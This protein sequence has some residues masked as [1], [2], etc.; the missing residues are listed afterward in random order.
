MDLFGED[1]VEKE[2]DVPNDSPAFFHED[3]AEG[4]TVPRSSAFMIGHGAQEQG[5]LKQFK[6]GRIPHGIILSGPKGIGKSTFAFRLGRFLLKHGGE[7]DLEGF[8]DFNVPAS[9]NVF[10]Q[11]A[12]GGHSDLL[13]VERA[14]DAAKDTYKNNV[15]VD[16]IRKI[17]PFL[18][19]TAS[20]KNGWRVVVI[21]DADTM[22]R[23]AQN[24]LLKILEEP[25]S[26]TVIILVCHRL[27]AM[28]ATIRSRAHVVSMDTLVQD[29]FNLLLERADHVLDDLES[30]TLY[31]LSG[32]SFGAA[33]DYI[34][35]GGF[36]TLSLI[37]NQLKNYP[38]WSWVEL[39]KLADQLV[40]AGRDQ[41]YNSFVQLLP[42]IFR[43]MIEAK[44]RGVAI[45][46]QAL[47]NET[48][49]NIHAHSS[50]EHLMNICENLKEHFARVERSNLDKRQ[51]V[52]GAFSII[53]A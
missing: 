30:D 40:R 35:L 23:N 7:Q 3:A 34:Q 46:S 17:N 21:D 37:L 32:G 47:Q 43:S 11:V 5:L 2:Q 45:N 31:N 33:L 52:L 22:N 15:V 27:G 18:H 1:I 4:L 48:V 25:P 13:V 36:D 51:A 10:K 8:E 29:D 26:N 6:T 12:S 50:L 39:H 44:A 16:D 28:V 49:Q 20:R 9:D 53:A 38:R 24:A 14:Y 41:S 19:M 42:W